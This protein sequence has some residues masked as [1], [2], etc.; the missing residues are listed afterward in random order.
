MPVGTG[1][2]WIDGRAAPVAGVPVF[3]AAFFAAL[4]IWAPFWP[5]WLE[6]RGLSASSVGVVLA[7]GFWTQVASEPL[8][9]RMADRTPRLR[10]LILFL[11]ITAVTGY[12]LFSYASALW[13]YLLLAAVV[14]ATFPVI[15]PLLESLAV[16]SAAREGVSYS[17]LR[18][19]GSIAFVAAS[20]GVGKLI[21][22]TDSSWIV[23][24]LIASLLATALAS[25]VLPALP[26]ERRTRPGSSPR[27]LGRQYTWFIVAACLA[28]ASHATYYG[29]SSIHWRAMGHSEAWIGGFWAMGVAA[30]V[31]LFMAPPLLIRRLDPLALVAVG[32]VG[33]IVRWT[34]LIWA[35]DA[36]MILVVQT[37]HA[38]SFGVTHL[39]TM[40]FMAQ[41]VPEH[42]SST[43]MA[44]YTA[45]LAGL[46]MGALLPSAGALFDAFGGAA[47][48]LSTT[49]S[50]LALLVAI[51]VAGKQVWNWSPTS[52]R[53]TS[54]GSLA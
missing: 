13:M 18:L 44:I 39:G 10:S 17:R 6:S 49:V 4:G 36:S 23:L 22:A 29:F 34:A 48:L 9:G 12:A 35:T 28:Q 21:E 46:G 5:L 20:L 54:P 47:F 8:I 1:K 37:L 16:R 3:Y 31:V 40:K 30:E 27:G 15:L 32:A 11:L 42:L 14:G 26:R 24:F 7:T 52:S 50:S 19:W 53:K 2:L 41:R 38:V 51:A 33:G 45:S 25:R 43:A